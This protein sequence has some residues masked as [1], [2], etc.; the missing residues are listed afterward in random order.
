MSGVTIKLSKPVKAH[1]EEVSELTLREPTT[2]D[3][4]ELG[5]PYAVALSEQN[6]IVFDA[7]VV[8]KYLVKLAGVPLSSIDQLSL[9]DFQALQGVV[10]GFFGHSEADG[11]QSET[12]PATSLT[13]PSSLPASGE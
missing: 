8:A 1:G 12:P 2:K 3:V 5:F 9:P 13:A 7:A 4:R 10:Q 6:R 11:E